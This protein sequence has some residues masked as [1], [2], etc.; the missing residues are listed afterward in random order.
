MI[1]TKKFVYDMFKAHKR[2]LI[3]ISIIASVGSLFAVIVPYIYGRL[4]DL[5]LIPN[6]T[7][8]LLLSLIVIW[9]VL[10]LISSYTSNKT[11]VLGEVLGAT[12]SMK[13]EADAYSHFLTLPISFHKKERSGK[14]L[15]KISRGSLSL[16]SMIET[17]S[18]IFPQFLILLFSLIAMMIIQWQLALIIIFSFVIYSVLTIRMT[19]KLLESQEKIHRIYEKQ[20]GSVYDKLY[21]VF[22]IKNFAME[23][24]EKKKF[25]NSLVGKIIPP[26]KRNAEKWKNMS[27]LQSIIYDLSFVLVLSASIFF[28]RQGSITQGEFIMFFGYIHLSFSPFF[29]LSSVYRRFKRSSVSVKRF[30][31]LK[32][33]VPEAMKHGEKV[34][35]NP[36]GEIEIK[37]LSFGYTKDKDTLKNLNLKI[38]AGETVA[39]IGESGVGKTTLSELIIGYYQPRE[40]KILMDGIDISELKLK[41]LRE[42]IAIVPQE[43]SVFND[44]LLNNIKYANPKSSLDDIVKAAKA[45]FAHDFIMK[46]PKEYDTMVGE[47]GIKLS[48][49]QKQRLALTMAFLKNPKILI[50]DEPTAS[51]DAGSEVKV[52]EGIRDLIRG[53]TTIIIAHRFSTI[54]NADKIVVLDKGRIVEV[55]NHN[56]LLRKRG[57]Y[58]KFHR[59][60]TGLD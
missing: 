17:S 39:L 50:L 16:S 3:I 19:K 56:E 41:W 22:L 6:T 27:F 38:K 25:F 51:L 48:T 55:G 46:L 44:T 35:E 24:N 12:T 23:E 54:K 10:S 14:V 13:A 58:Y 36:K 20:Y 11:A 2:E 57:L 5:A 43:I 60:Q 8:N 49:G 45:A 30:V 29:R 31:R 42:Q 26:I 7:I 33:I 18:E 4:F 9:A 52:Q 37:N 53:R 34:L 1:S 40:G 15:Q 21:N 47:R 28:L 32:N 59:L